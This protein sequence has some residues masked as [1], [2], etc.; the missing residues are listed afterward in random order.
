[1]QG[2][3]LSLGA[4]LVRVDRPHALPH[5][6]RCQRL[7]GAAPEGA[8][9]DLL[10]FLLDPALLLRF[11]PLLSS[12]ASQRLAAACVLWGKVRLIIS[13]PAPCSASPQGLAR[14][15]QHILTAAFIC[16]RPQLCVLEDRLQRLATLA[17]SNDVKALAQVK[18]LGRAMPSH[19]CSFYLTRLHPLAWLA[20]AAG[21][22]DLGGRRAPRLA[23]A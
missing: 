17:G 9:E 10:R 2:W 8:R 4:W 3:L 21:V 6:C 5:G 1:M 23:G 14:L 13:G 15:F 12:R 11:N 19:D 18:G 16:T 7:A 20:G 22:Q